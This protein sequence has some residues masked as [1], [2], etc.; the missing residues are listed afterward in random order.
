[1]HLALVDDRLFIAL[2]G[3]VSGYECREGNAGL[4]LS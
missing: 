2:V 3:D 4:E 1:M